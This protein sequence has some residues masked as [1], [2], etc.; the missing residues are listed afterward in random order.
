LI[1]SNP[2]SDELEG[3]TMEHSMKL[4][5]KIN[6]AAIGVIAGLTLAASGAAYAQANA[7]PAAAPTPPAPPHYGSA[8]SVDKARDIAAAARKKALSEGWAMAITIVDN[9]GKLIYFEK[10]DDTQS[11]SIDISM[12]K[13]RTAALFK[14]PT[15]AFNDA[16]S[17]GATYVLGM[18]NVIAVP[19]GFP[20]M[21]Q[22]KMVG[23]I[24]VSG[25]TSPQ[26]S[27]VAKAGLAVSLD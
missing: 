2:L 14:R 7:A 27:A 19:G 10:M 22:G 20:L 5:K 4:V 17:S 11:G 21:S 9:D 12:A 16:L 15:Q 6:Q 23:A 8:V 1:N 24:G 13:A 26:D 3:E 25:G 18:P